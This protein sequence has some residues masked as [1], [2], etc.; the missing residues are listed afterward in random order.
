[1]LVIRARSTAESAQ[2][3]A[4]EQAHPPLSTAISSDPIHGVIKGYSEPLKMPSILIE[5]EIEHHSQAFAGVI[6]LTG[7]PE[8]GALADKEGFVKIN[9]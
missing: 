6:I 2:R 7:W 8:H 4:D 9:K 5:K 3:K 1:M